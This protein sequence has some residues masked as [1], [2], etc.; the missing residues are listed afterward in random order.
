M[1]NAAPVEALYSATYLEDYLDI[2]ENVPL[3]I[4][5]KVSQIL[6]LDTSCQSKSPF[7]FHLTFVSQMS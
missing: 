4:Q 5:D 1:M 2:V 7:A 3:R 6:E